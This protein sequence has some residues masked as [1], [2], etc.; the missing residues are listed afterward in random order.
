MVLSLDTLVA[1]YAADELFFETIII[2]I[3]NVAVLQNIQH[4]YR[5]EFLDIIVA[6]YTYSENTAFPIEHIYIRH[7]TA[8]LHKTCK[9]MFIENFDSV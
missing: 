4:V 9:Q 1:G 7:E 8:S 6:L 5:I 3:L 2:K